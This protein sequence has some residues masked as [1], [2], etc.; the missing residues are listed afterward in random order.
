MADTLGPSDPTF[1]TRGDSHPEARL[2]SRRSK[3][4][5]HSNRTKRPAA[6]KAPVFFI[7]LIVLLVIKTWLMRDFALGARNPLGVAFEAGFAVLLLGLVDI[8]PPRRMYWLDLAAYSLLSTVL[9]A[10][11]VYVH[12]YQQLFDPHMLA[13]AGQLGSVS[14]AVAELIKP[15]YVLFFLD[16]PLLAVWVVMLRREAR[17]QRE[18]LA[19][20]DDS[21]V[22]REPHTL[23]QPK[24]RS[25]KV[26]V[27]TL[28][29]AVVVAGQIAT[30]LQVP[31]YVDGVAVAKARGLTIAQA[32]VFI[33][34]SDAD[35]DPGQDVVAP[36][37][38]VSAAAT[39]SVA[40]TA[41][42]TPG[43]KAEARI[44][45]IRGAYEGS[46]ITT[47]AAGA[48]KGKNVIIIQVEALNEMIEQK[49]IDGHEI[50]PNLN[51][52]IG[53]SWY[54][55]NGYSETGI[56]NT[57]DA[58]FIV[59]SSLFSPRA[60]AAS[61]AYAD[62]EVP[63]L[64]RLLNGLGYDTFTMH[65]NAVAYWN[66]KEL[67]GALGFKNYYDR[68]FF[69][70]PDHSVPDKIAMGS[71]DEVLFKKALPLLQSKEA[72]K[73]P[74]YAQIITL[75]SHTPFEFI[76]MSRRPVK[77]PPEY[78]GSL[79]GNY[80]SAQSYMDMALGKFIDNLKA[81]KVWDNSIVVIYGDHTAAMDAAPEGTD[82]KVAEALLG[83][84]YGPS[85]RQRVSVIIHL[86]GQKQGVTRTDT[87]GEVDIM[88]T[89]AD[90]LGVDLTQVP[91]MGRSMF[92]GSNALVPFNSYLPGGS[93]A[94]SRVVFAP[95]LGFDDGTA[96][97]IGD[98]LPTKATE[99]DETDYERGLELV[100]LSDK[101]VKSLPKRADA[102]SL[103]DAWIPDPTARKAAAPLGAKQKGTG[104]AP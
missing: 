37:T 101:W 99:R 100:N 4:G 15:A 17:K 28:I 91:H 88:P 95:G 92:V 26:A 73:T 39:A 9:F 60:Q 87:V 5:T 74:F 44:E 35:D 58:E 24:K 72:S 85:D 43:G 25:W 80:V 32:V 45:R 54:F 14:D 53:E 70:N 57:A 13:M 3:G 97:N 40:S 63:A 84:D 104:S 49:K 64:P 68:E 66:R 8:I 41:A 7:V 52:L 2:R 42:L 19:H 96:Y 82:A 16:I 90:L 46:R 12:F 75:S 38:R 1:R 30:T 34:R 48:F 79:F 23:I 98:S 83:R 103:G 89:V 56:G 59:N 55:P 50:L 29:A 20:L 71:S 22:R 86:P 11:T 10:M 61:V 77:T 81:T 62:R 27:V 6:E 33:P 51:K 47:F 94:N 21:A 67:Y 93:F 69:R 31:D 76:P 18:R 102:G 36:G 65:T 78:A